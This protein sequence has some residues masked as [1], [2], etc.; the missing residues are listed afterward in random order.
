MLGLNELPDQ[1]ALQTYVSYVVRGL[2][3]IVLGSVLLGLFISALLFIA[4]LHLVNSGYA[5]INVQV[6]ILVIGLLLAIISFVI[7]DMCINRKIKATYTPRNFIDEKFEYFKN[8]TIGAAT[9]FMEGLFNNS[10][11]R[12]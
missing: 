3:F 11:N 12:K 2:F 7:A 8:V 1:A 6:I 4:Y 10:K 5:E 9:G